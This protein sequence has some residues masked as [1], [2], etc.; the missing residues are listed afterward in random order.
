MCQV[1]WSCPVDWTCELTLPSLCMLTLLLFYLLKM[2]A[3][4]EVLLET[5]VDP[6][7]PKAITNAKNL[8]TSCQ[9]MCKQTY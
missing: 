7:E 8:F 9:N 3:S 4:V 1:F 6:E 5:P 2:M